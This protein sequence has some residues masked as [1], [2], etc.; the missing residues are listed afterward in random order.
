MSTAQVLPSWRPLA[1]RRTGLAQAATATLFV[2]LGAG[3][4]A[5]AAQHIKHFGT[6]STLQIAQRTERAAEPAD[7]CVELK[8]IK[9]VLGL[10]VSELAQLFGVSRPT[11]YSWQ[12]GKRI[13]EGNAKRIRDI[14]RALAPRLALLDAQVGR[15]AHRAIDGRMTLLQKLSEGADAEQ[16]IGKLAD[17]LQR[18]AVQRERLA[19]RLRGR[20]TDRGS[21]DLDDLG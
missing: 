19:S 4:E 1:A 15:I 2:V 21:P 10:S 5:D 14:A 8:T 18:E 16:A 20:N 13:S 17:I 6:G 7:L 3:A 11:I 9:D 12:E